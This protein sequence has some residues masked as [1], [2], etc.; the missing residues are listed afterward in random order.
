MLL[1]TG[2]ITAPIPC[3]RTSIDMA[4][5]RVVNGDGGPRAARLY[6]M[7]TVIPRTRSFREGLVTNAGNTCLQ[8][9]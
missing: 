8:A 3:K 4:R 1:S 7:L 5:A 6:V 2:T 9:V